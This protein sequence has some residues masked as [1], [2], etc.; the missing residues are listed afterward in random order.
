VLIGIAVLAGCR[1]VDSHGAGERF[2]P[3]SDPALRFSGRWDLR[4]P[5]RP[6]AS[7]PGFAVSTDFQGKTIQVRMSDPGNYFNVEIDGRHHGVIGG[8]DGLSTYLLASDLDAGAHHIRLQRRNISFDDPTVIEGFIVDEEARLSRPADPGVRIE[9]IGDSFTAAEG[10]EAKA[11]TLPWEEKFPVTDFAKGYAALLARAM[12]ADL[13]AVCRSGSGVLTTWNGIRELPMPERYGWTLMEDPKPAWDF[14]GPSPGLVVI[15]LGLNDS[16]GLK[17]ADGTV[18][19]EAS[20]QFRAAYHRMIA[21][22]WKRHPA[23]KIVA[24]APFVPWARVMISAVVAE[25]KATGTKEIYYAQFDHFEGGYVADGHPTVATHRKMA[26]QI[27]AQ[28]IRLG[29]SPTGAKLPETP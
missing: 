18:G 2:V 10:N 13:T 28:F 15:S 3:A 29:L 1:K 12:N 11:A 4:D 17:G 22:V 27:L 24:L 25:E 19:P 23:A 5:A 26:E 21:E 7:W 8:K 14:G 9:F 6:R 16:G 20:G